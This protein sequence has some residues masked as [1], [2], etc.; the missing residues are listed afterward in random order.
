MTVNLHYT[1]TPLDRADELRRD[2]D[3]IEH[4]WRQPETIV[5]PVFELKNLISTSSACAVMNPRADLPSFIADVETPTFLGLMNNTAVFSYNCDASVAARWE[6]I[7]DDSR[8]E[9]LRVVG[10]SLPHGHASLLA[11]SRGIS[12]WQKLN[13]YCAAC[14]SE[15][16][17]G[18][19]GH[20]LMCE[21]STCGQLWF[22][23]TDPAVIMLIERED[24]NGKNYCLLGRSALW[25]KHVFSTL[26]GFVETGES[27]EQAVIR[28]VYEEANITVENV[29]Y[30]ASQ[31]WPFPQS[32]MVGFIGTATSEEIKIDPAEL[33]DAR[34]FEAGEIRTFGNWGDD[35]DGP[36][37]PRPD[38]IARFLI[39]HWLSVKA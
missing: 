22:P 2:A 7:D 9:D 15:A 32:I 24:R 3:Q 10:P 17:L 31:P 26:A 28:E 12:H 16:R 20:V 14:G 27:L 23:R 30:V 6:T 29:R 18:N 33:Q 38:S 39:D 11:Y 5:L 35:G 37:L 1:D 4:L 34:W 8:F 13:R 36:K 25:P 19:A 21:S